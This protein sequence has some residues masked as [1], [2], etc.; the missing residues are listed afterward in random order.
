M[1]IIV[2]PILVASMLS[3]K[4]HYN[5]VAIQLRVETEDLKDY[6]LNK[7]FTQIIVVPIASLNKA[8]LATLQYARSLSSYVIALNVSTDNKEI[9]KLKNRW[10]KLDTDILLVS[11]YSTYRTVVTPLLGYI[12]QIA[13]A[14]SETEKITVMIPQFITHEGLG[15]FLHNHTGFIIRESLLRN[16][17]VIVSTYPYHL[18]DNDA[19]I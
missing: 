6:N 13:N 18:E 4:K 11:K 12:N 1:V 16:K 9:D 3:I 10:A 8:A 7:P 5:S 14:T 17:N 19:E 15:E 2:I